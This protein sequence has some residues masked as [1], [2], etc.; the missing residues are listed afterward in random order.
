MSPIVQR[1]EV[2]EAGDVKKGALGKRQN[3]EF[4]H[5]PIYLKALFLI[6]LCFLCFPCI[7][8]PHPTPSPLFPR[9]SPL[10]TWCS[11]NV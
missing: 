1:G 3:W 4:N 10:E 8:L 6:I 2:T 7:L 11:Q 9:G 5:G